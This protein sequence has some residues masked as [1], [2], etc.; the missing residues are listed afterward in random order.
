MTDLDIGKHCGN[1]D[2]KRLDFL[3]IRC[4]FCNK[5]FCK[6]HIIGLNHDCQNIPAIEIGDGIVKVYKCSLDYCSGTEHIEIIC[7]CCKLV[8]CLTH[9]HCKDHNCMVCITDKSPKKTY[10]IDSIVKDIIS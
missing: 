9:R 1:A 10:A 7:Q 4:P 2:C 5:H 8:F 6:N 3:P